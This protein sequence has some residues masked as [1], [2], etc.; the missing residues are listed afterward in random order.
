MSQKLYVPWSG[1]DVLLFLA[2]WLAAQLACGVIAG[3]VELVTRHQQPAVETADCD[4]QTPE[5]PAGRHHG[6]PVTQLV[7][8]SKESLVVFLSLILFVVVATPLVEELLFRK[9]LQGWLEAK[10][11]QLG[12][13]GGS[14]IAIVFVSFVFALLHAG[15]IDEMSVNALFALLVAAAIANI[16]VF[17]LG[18]YYLMNMRN[19]RLAHCLFGHK[20]FSRKQLLT[21]AGWCLLAM[22]VVY[23]ISFTADLLAPNTN[24]DPIPIF[25]FSLVLG[26]LYSITRNLWY[27]V[28]LH[29]CLNLTSLILAALFY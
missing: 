27:C 4:L 28:L 19:M 23:G 15:N 10:L 26:V 14:G 2:L 9:L 24:T 17:T 21:M 22:L 13:P 8:K 16:L 29:A 3:T 20:R 5:E 11:S 25:V 7:T 12:V 1:I 6:H 18:I